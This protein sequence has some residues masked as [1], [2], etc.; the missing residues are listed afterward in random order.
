[1]A[2]M[3]SGFDRAVG[4]IQPS[5][6]HGAPE[7]Q[8]QIGLNGGAELTPCSFRLFDAGVGKT[9]VECVTHDYAFVAIDWTAP[10]FSGGATLTEAIDALRAVFKAQADDGVPGVNPDEPSIQQ[11]RMGDVFA[12][13]VKNVQAIVA[14][15]EERQRDAAN[16]VVERDR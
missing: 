9:F 1:M 3:L 11:Q 4:P 14:H 13:I 15:A 12:S 16:S 5:E 6:H 10:H 2:K 8:C 7:Y